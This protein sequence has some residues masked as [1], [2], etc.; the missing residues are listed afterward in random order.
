M[1]PFKTMKCVCGATLLVPLVAGAFVPPH[2]CR[3][4]REVCPA[5]VGFNHDDTEKPGVPRAPGRL[6]YEVMGTSTSVVSSNLI[7]GPPNMWKPKG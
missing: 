1:Y 6:T 5:V 3:A 7:V 2:E 4:S